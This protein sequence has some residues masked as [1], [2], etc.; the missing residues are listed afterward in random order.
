[1]RTAKTDQTERVPRLIWVFAGRT[2]FFCWFCHVAV[3]I[4]F[5]V[6]FEFSHS[7]MAIRQYFLLNVP[8]RCLKKSSYYPTNDTACNL[9]Y[10]LGSFHVNIPYLW[11]FCAQTE[12]KSLNWPWPWLVIYSCPGL[13]K[14][15]VHCWPC[16]LV[17]SR[18]TTGVIFTV[19]N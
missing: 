5:N 13:D 18:L 11:L 4:A 8:L 16:P 9:K 7:I 1:M 15:D 19:Q 3:Y 6:N 14:T 10:P 2:K 17:I 12:K